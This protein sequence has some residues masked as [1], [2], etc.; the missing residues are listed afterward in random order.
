VT[1]PWS[2]SSLGVPRDGLPVNAGGEGVSTIYVKQW[3]NC[4]RCSDRPGTVR[5]GDALAFTHG[6]GQWWCE[7][8][9][10]EVQLEHARERAAVIPELEQRLEA[11]GGPWV[12]SAE[13]AA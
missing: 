9:A 2:T 11:E 12:R 1:K 3:G 13:G 8:C 7:R 10:T 6:G 4:A 5:W